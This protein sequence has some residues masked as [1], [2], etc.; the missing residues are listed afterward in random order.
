MQGS[1]IRPTTDYSLRLPKLPNPPPVNALPS[2]TSNPSSL[3]WLEP[4]S[5]MFYWEGLL[6]L[7]EAAVPREVQELKCL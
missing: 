7:A 1:H 2:G 6:R 4:C 3:Q 5:A